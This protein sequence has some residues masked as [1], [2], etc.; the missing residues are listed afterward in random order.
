MAWYVLQVVEECCARGLA[1]LQ[2]LPARREARRRF[3]AAAVTT[4]GSRKREASR[5]IYRSR[6]RSITLSSTVCPR[7][8]M[9]RSVWSP[10]LLMRGAQG[11]VGP[12]S[13]EA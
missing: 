4:M 7:A 5:G 1:I 9:E 12:G 8:A 10:L 6:W 11:S 3:A 13:S 2:Q